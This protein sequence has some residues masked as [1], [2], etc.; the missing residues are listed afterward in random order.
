[1]KY[2]TSLGLFLVLATAALAGCTPEGSAPGEGDSQAEDLG[3]GDAQSIETLKSGSL[4][5]DALQDAVRAH[6]AAK[7]RGRG[8]LGVESALQGFTA[9]RAERGLGADDTFQIKTVLT[10]EVGDRHARLE[11]FHKGVRVIGSTAIL[12]TD[13]AGEAREELTLGLR[14]GVTVDTTPVLDE[15]A[16]RAVVDARPER[17]GE[18]LMEPRFELVI[19]P[20]SRRFVKATGLP[21]SATD[22]IE[23]A[24]ELERRVVAHRLAYQIDTH[25]RGPEGHVASRRFFVDAS[26]GE[27]LQVKSLTENLGDGHTFKTNGPSNNFHVPMSTYK[28]VED[29]PVWWEPRD[30]YR[31]FGVWDDDFSTTSGP[32]HDMNNLWGTG[33]AFAG[34]NATYQNRQTAIADSMY[35]MQGTWD[36]F[37]RV[38]NWRGYDNDFYAGHAYVHVGDNW[39]NASYNY[40]SG[41][42]SIGDGGN[43]LM[44]S[45]DIVAHEYG[46]GM[47]DF[48]ADLGGNA[49]GE[50]LN[51]ANSDIIGEISEAYE[52]GNGLANGSLVIPAV[53][54]PN[55]AS[56]V[57]RNFRT[58][59]GIRYWYAGLEDLADEHARALPMDHAFFFLAYGS[60][61]NPCSSEFSTYLPW[62]TGGIGIDAAA[63]IWM[64]SLFYKFDSSTDY[65]AA[66]TL[67]LQSA[68][69]LFGSGSFQYK[70]V[71]NAFAAI[72]V[73]SRA[74]D[75]P[76]NPVS[77]SES[78]PNNTSAGA[79]AVASGTLPA[80]A[81]ITGLLSKRTLT[82]GGVSTSD[83]A[84]WYWITVPSGKT[85]HV[86]MFPWNDTDIGVYDG[87]DT[88]VDQSTSGGTTQEEVL[89]TAPADGLPHPYSLRLYHYSTAFGQLPFY[90]A[91]VD[92]Y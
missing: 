92:I 83:A 32:N 17:A 22:E 78:E 14:A 25:D 21:L 20:V 68:A 27:V 77:M 3:G 59:N 79:D 81:P 55:W 40:G 37:D 31:N 80:G 51:E 50:G 65:A 61:S 18:A 72:A 54:G 71:Q 89:V 26:T 56:S 38:W 1:M 23:N 57:G 62:G 86:C 60:S 69:E 53:P 7:T 9:R 58:A 13:P 24:E 2:R 52:V 36:M 34:A 75:Y 44:T 6:E 67:M 16:A 76:A 90:Q 66:R 45:Y 63:R 64:R 5:I 12:H 43:S 82:A 28:H 15:K 87:F 84:D 42:I 88:L 30:T 85:L 19:Y 4:Q 10:D 48:T 70:G 39:Y 74:S 11:H 73:G 47:N 41:N 91:Y 35:S 29:S 8:A 33:E 46:H 49:E